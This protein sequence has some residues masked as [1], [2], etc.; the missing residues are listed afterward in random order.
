MKNTMIILPL[1]VLFL[2]S[3]ISAPTAFSM[4]EHSSV[5]ITRTIDNTTLEYVSDEFNFIFSEEEN[6]G[7][8]WWFEFRDTVV[9][10][11][12]DLL[13]NTF[14]DVEDPDGHSI[15]G[16]DLFTARNDK[17]SDLADNE[18]Y[19]I[20]KFDPDAVWEMEQLERRGIGLTVAL[21][22]V[23]LFIGLIAIALIIGI[24]I[25]GSGMAGVSISIVF[26]LTT[27]LL[28]WGILS[29]ISSSVLLDFPMMGLLIWTCL[30]LSYVLGVVLSLSPSTGEE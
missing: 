3:M 19:E 12:R 6:Y 27:F 16:L 30:T 9:R 7:Y 17:G 18:V 28:L 4:G 20:I 22:F 15:M 2:L 26:R 14:G 5:V 10:R 29:A 21:I 1:A 11:T 24:R 13:D 25:L 23:A 8:W